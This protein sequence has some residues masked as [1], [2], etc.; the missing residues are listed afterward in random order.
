[1]RVPHLALQIAH[2]RPGTQDV[3]DTLSREIKMPAKRWIAL[4]AAVVCLPLLILVHVRSSTD[5][6]PVIRFSEDGSTAILEGLITDDSEE[7][8]AQWLVEST[9]SPVSLVLSGPGGDGLAAFRLAELIELHGQVSTTVPEKSLCASACTVTWLAGTRRSLEEGAV[10]GFHGA[11][12]FRIGL[13]SSAEIGCEQFIAHY[14]GIYQRYLDREPMIAAYVLGNNALQLTGDELLLIGAEG[15]GASNGGS[16][17]ENKRSND[18]IPDN[19]L[20]QVYFGLMYRNGNTTLL[21]QP[22]CSTCAS[23]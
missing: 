12:C 22:D 3:T 7:I 19:A 5:P 21:P 16:D 23:H 9:G 1:M 11:Q 6:E 2:D 17:T 10:L 15:V 13:T 18:L 14:A 8:L 4:L 20:A